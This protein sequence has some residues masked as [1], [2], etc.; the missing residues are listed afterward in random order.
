VLEI[1]IFLLVIVW[2]ELGKVILNELLLST[3]QKVC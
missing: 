2:G 1:W 3:V